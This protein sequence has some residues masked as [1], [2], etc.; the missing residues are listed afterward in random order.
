[1]LNRKDRKHNTEIRLSYQV[2]QKTSYLLEMIQSFLG[3]NIG[4]RK[5]TD[6]YYYSSTSFI[7]AHNVINYFDKFNLLSSKYLNYL[8]WREAYLLIQS[9]E[10][11][12]SSG[13]SQIRILKNTMNN[14]STET[15]NLLTETETET[16]KIEI[17][18]DTD[19]DTDI[20][21]DA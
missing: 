15:F 7:I 17:Y 5:P 4:Y 9:K 6:T 11:L 10:H 19:E 20:N 16:D 8:K 1:M 13:I 12:E 14:C 3:G 21:T 18:N 2:D